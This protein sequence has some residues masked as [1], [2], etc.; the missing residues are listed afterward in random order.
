MRRSEMGFTY[1]QLAQVSGVSRRT[2]VAIET[3]TSPGSMETWFRLSTA[4]NI[5][6][7]ELFDTSPRPVTSDIAPTAVFDSS[8]P[9]VL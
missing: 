7:R 1:D 8:L 6:F 4:L 9:T 5:G 2:I 3:G